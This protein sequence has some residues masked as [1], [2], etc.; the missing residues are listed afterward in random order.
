[1]GV[2]EIVGMLHT[3]PEFLGKVVHVEAIPEKKAVFRACSRPFPKPIADYLQQR[4]LHLYRHQCEAVDSVRDGKDVII[5]T[6]TASGKTL[7]F[8]LPVFEIL[9]NDPR[10]TALYL[11]P[12]KALSHDQLKTLLEMELLT[13]IEA[14][15]AVYDG[16]TPRDK[17]VTIRNRSRIVISNPHELH[18]LLPW[19]HQWA[20]F[21][22]NLAVIVID[23]AHQHRGVSGSNM[24]FLIRRLRRICRQYGKDPLFVLSS[25]TIANPVAFAEKLTGKSVRCISADGSP[26]GPKHFILYNPCSGGPGD[27]APY[28]ESGKILGACLDAG[29]NTLC[30]TG[31][32]KLTEII[33]LQVRD[34]IIRERKGDPSLVSAYRAGYLAEERRAIENLMKTGEL[35]GIVSTNA[36]ELGVDIGML[37]AVIMTGF[38]GTIMSTWQQ[39]GRAGRSS[40]DSLAVLV[41]NPDPLDQ[42][43][44]N[45]PA[46]FFSASHEQ[47]IIDLKN[48]YIL[49]GQVLC[50]SAEIPL[51]PEVD[52]EFFGNDLGDLLISLSGEQLV[53]RTRRGWIYSGTQR[54]TEMAGISNITSDLF[55]IVLDGTTIET[56]DRSQAFREAHTGAILYHQGEKY[57]V[58]SLDIERKIARVEHTDVDY[59]TKVLQSVSVAIVSEICNREIGNYRLSFGDVLVTEKVNAYRIIRYDTTLS[60]EPLDLPPLQ[61]HTRALWF[62]VPE[63]TCQKLTTGDFDCGGSLH[64]AEHAIIAMMPFY[65]MCDRKDIGGF[66]SPNFPGTGDPTVL[67][68]DAYEGGIGLAENAYEQFETIACSTHG[69]VSTCGCETGC[70]SCIY[71]PKCGNDNKPLD[72]KGTVL[73]LGEISHPVQDQSSSPGTTGKEQEIQ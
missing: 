41:A 20:S 31:S 40:G 61:F 13:G 69:M 36:L 19:H 17:R 23:E 37:D 35:K 21:Y 27:S 56:M 50:A 47:A 18:C 48:P 64:G 65:V 16:D 4:D 73:I 71:S 33:T 58:R 14:F 45:H 25:A 60:V 62:R 8:N 70:P 42:Y 34:S 9:N 44:M 49:S 51:V 67:I 6:A 2:D 5:T 28:K 30:F 39:A 1:M 7:A 15:P 11:Y 3:S 26:H 63:E 22:R 29:I 24:A 52:A 53:C 10:A 59:Y 32:R 55:K 66:S 43:F 54:P 72:K 57:L 46:M 38:P 12:T 68:Y